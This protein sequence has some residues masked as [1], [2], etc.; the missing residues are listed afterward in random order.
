MIQDLSLIV[1]NQTELLNSIEENLKGTKHYIE[2]A[3][4]N[5]ESA[6]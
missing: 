1:K 2:K 5:L 3:T 6:K 4:K